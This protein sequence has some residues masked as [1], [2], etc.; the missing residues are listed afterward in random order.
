MVIWSRLQTNWQG[1]T[2]HEFT[3]SDRYNFKICQKLTHW[4]RA[5]NFRC[6]AMWLIFKSTHLV[7]L[8]HPITVVHP[9]KILLHSEVCDTPGWQA[10]IYSYRTEVTVAKKFQKRL[11]NPNPNLV[12]QNLSNSNPIQ[13]HHNFEIPPGLN[14]NPCSSLLLIRQTRQVCHGESVC[15]FNTIGLFQ[16]R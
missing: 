15:W 4:A 14:P 16:Y 7:H 5:K 8:V 9:W 13:N 10:L 6:E 11:S 1:K 12:K 3:L 2:I